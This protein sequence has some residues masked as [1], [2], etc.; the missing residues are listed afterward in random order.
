MMGS[1]I[2]MKIIYQ[3]GFSLFW[4]S[5]PNKP[6]FKVA[7]QPGGCYF[8]LFGRGKHMVSDCFIGFDEQQQ[9]L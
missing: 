6:A 8:T 3:P 1:D 4:D 2:W 9:W 7:S 5:Y